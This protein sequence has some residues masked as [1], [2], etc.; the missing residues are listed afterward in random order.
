MFRPA[1]LA[2]AAIALLSPCV[3]AAHTQDTTNTAGVLV[4][5]N[6]NEARLNRLQPPDQVMDA[7]GIQPGMVGAEIGAGRGRYVVQLAVRVGEEGKVYAEDIDAASLRHLDQR[8]ERWGLTNVVSVLGDVTDPRLPEGE[9]DFIFVISAYHHFS[10]PTTLLRKARSALKPDGMVAIGEWLQST[11]P[12]EI[13][14]QMNAAGYAL[15]RTET[16]LEA[17]GLYI[18]VFRIAERADS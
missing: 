14:S 7:I 3:P 17:N 11:S 15:E 13:E 16:F 9:L 4:P 5:E 1:A 18:Y 10:D 2:I 12:E 8:C 6:S